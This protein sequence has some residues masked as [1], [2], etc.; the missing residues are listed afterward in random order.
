M[1]YTEDW[2]NIPTSGWVFYN[3]P[4]EVVMELWCDSKIIASAYISDFM[5]DLGLTYED[6]M[7]DKQMYYDKF[8][9]MFS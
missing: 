5:E 8:I 7:E 6:F 9:E 1:I 2:D 3:D 4:D